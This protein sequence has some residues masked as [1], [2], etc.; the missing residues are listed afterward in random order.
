MQFV[1]SKSNICNHVAV[2]NRKSEFF[3]S[4]YKLL[5]IFISTTVVF[6][7]LYRRNQY[8]MKSILSYE[9]E[10]LCSGE[11][12]P[13]IPFSHENEFQVFGM[14]QSEYWT[15]DEFKVA[16][17]HYRGLITYRCLATRFEQRWSTFKCWLTERTSNN[18]FLQVVKTKMFVLKDLNITSKLRCS[19]QTRHVSDKNHNGIGFGE[20]KTY[21][22]VLWILLVKNHLCRSATGILCFQFWFQRQFGTSQAMLV[23]LFA[24]RSWKLVY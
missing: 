11:N 15:R 6:H 17:A 1:G 7:T 4:H 9:R 2:L 22:I 12:G 20:K 14:K 23:N 8:F 10:S 3:Y 19:L 13:C 18:Y 24:F 16:Q 21:A 5:I